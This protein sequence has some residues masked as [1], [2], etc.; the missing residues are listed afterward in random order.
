MSKTM[1]LLLTAAGVIAVVVIVIAL[2]VK[3]IELILALIL[4]AIALPCAFFGIKKLRHA[5]HDK[6]THHSDAP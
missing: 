1:S 4:L 3:A 2:I 6:L 5:A